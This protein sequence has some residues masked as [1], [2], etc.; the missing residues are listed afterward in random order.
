[1]EA[2]ALLNA[3]GARLGDPVIHPR[4]SAGAY[5]AA[6]NACDLVLSP[7]PFGGL[8]STVDALRLGLPVAAMEGLE[9][10]SRT[11][12]MILRRVGMPERLICRTPQAYVELA[13]ELIDKVEFRLEMGNLALACDVDGKL[14]ANQPDGLRRKVVDTVWAAYAHHEAIQADGR[15]VWDLDALRGLG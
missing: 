12:A 2:Q 13:L 4:L 10:H 7:F 5:E 8:H 15:K 6:L 11:D 9:P 14:F 1:M 3:S